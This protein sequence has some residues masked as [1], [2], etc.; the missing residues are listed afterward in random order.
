MAGETP[1]PK[2]AIRIMGILNTT[3]DS[4]SDGG[5]HFSEQAALQ[6]A[7][8]MIAAG[9]DI[10]DIGG[11]S[12]RPYAEPVS[13]EEELRRVIPVIREIRKNHATPISIDTTKAAV[14]GEALAAGADIINDISALRKDMNM[15]A[16]V[17]TTTAPVI[18]MHMQGTPETMQIEPHYDDVVEEILEFFQERI[19]WVEKNGISCDRLILDPGIGFGKTRQHNLTILKHL[20]RFSGLGLPVLLGH[21]RKR[22]LGDITGLDPIHRDLP[23]AVVSALTSSLGV[24]I[25]RVHDVAT[26]RQALLI[27]EAIQNAP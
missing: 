25:V 17:K 22:F 1:L 4:F 14:A 23:T 5:R 8:A 9:A 26:T 13:I 6:Q 15:L 24:A 2:T 21:S 10:I 19:A 11:E 7:E 20:D 18:I 16:L 3:P 12:T 27:A